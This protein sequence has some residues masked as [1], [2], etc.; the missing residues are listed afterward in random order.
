MPYTSNKFLTI[1]VILYSLTKPVIAQNLLATYQLALQND[2]LIKASHANIEIATESKDQSIA[3]MLST[4]SANLG[5][6]KF[7]LTNNKDSGPSTIVTGE[8]S[9]DFSRNTFTLS[10]V[11]PIFHYDHWVQLDQSDNLAAQAEA[12]YYADLQELMLRTSEAYFNV[13][14]AQDELSFILAK[15]KSIGFQIEQANKRYKTG[16]IAITDVYEAQAGFDQA[17]A[18]VI[19]AKNNVDSAKE[20][21]REIIGEDNPV[22]LSIL[23][24][25]LPLQAPQP[26]DIEE[27]KQNAALNNLNIIA[28]INAV[29]VVKKSINLQRSGHFPTLDV[30]GAYGLIDNSADFALRGD[31][32][33]IGLQLNIPIFQGGAVN[34]RTRQAESEYTRQNELLKATKRSVNRRLKDSYRGVMASIARVKALESAVKSG[35]MSLRATETGFKVG[36]R[37]MVD[38]LAATENL[39]SAESRYSR[40]RYEYIINNFRLKQVTSKLSIDDLAAING[41]LK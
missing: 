19:A 21:L 24:E 8:G 1:L 2:P 23:G 22:E 32:T 34:S 13:L 7:W 25:K 20:Q 14:S 30:V 27:W 36:T 17:R 11:Q 26:A 9:I 38:V 31:V 12:Q 4:V 15:E 35:K 33:N 40:V 5:T 18:D 28:G 41:F 37:T 29:E 10:L 39:F 6:D 3:R 16:L